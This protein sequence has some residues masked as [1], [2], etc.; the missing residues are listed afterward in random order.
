MLAFAQHATLSVTDS[1]D[2]AQL[3]K[4]E[5]TVEILSQRLREFREHIVAT[6]NDPT[7]PP[8]VKSTA[9][10]LMITLESI[11]KK[12]PMIETE[13]EK[14]RAR[15][16][17]NRDAA[18]VGHYGEA[19]K[20][21][22]DAEHYK[23]A[24]AAMDSF[25]QGAPHHIASSI[26]TNKAT[27]EFSKKGRTVFEV[28]AKNEL[29]VKSASLRTVVESTAHE[30]PAVRHEIHFRDNDAQKMQGRQ[31][32]GVHSIPSDAIMQWALA[33]VLDFKKDAKLNT[34]EMSV[35]CAGLTND[36]VEALRIIAKLHDITCYTQNAN[37]QL[38]QKDI[39]SKAKSA[40]KKYGG[41]GQILTA[42]DAISRPRGPR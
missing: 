28:H 5:R 22:S 40:E 14:A 19:A 9:N 12:L 23:T 6:Q 34:G 16:K 20:L 17:Q 27:I 15:G 18:K 41:Q 7:A 10:R 35:N 11:Y 33:R 29:N 31:R 24:K 38:N 2:D 8:E 30:K 1:R 3:Q 4:I 42:D 37:V 39:E 25:F 36:T 32:V 21:F 26:G 13:I